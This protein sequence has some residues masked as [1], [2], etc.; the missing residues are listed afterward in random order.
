MQFQFNPLPQYNLTASGI[1]F[2]YYYKYCVQYCNPVSPSLHPIN[3][4]MAH[5][6]HIHGAGPG[7]LIKTFLVL[8]LLHCTTF[9]YGRLV[10]ML[11]NAIGL[12]SF[13]SER[14]FTCYVL[15]YS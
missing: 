13:H 7:G 8:K 3:P 11:R 4:L 15:S 14:R 5:V 12:L 10:S 6:L 2:Y 9:E 1:F